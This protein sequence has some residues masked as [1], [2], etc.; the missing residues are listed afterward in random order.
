MNLMTKNKKADYLNTGSFAKKAISEAKMYG[1]VNVVASSEE[2]NY[3]FIP[4]EYTLSKDA[5][6]CSYY[7]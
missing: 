2:Q 5:E 4:K 3:T 1:T 7:N 6:L